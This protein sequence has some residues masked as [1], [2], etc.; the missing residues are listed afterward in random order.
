MNVWNFILAFDLLPE[1][2]S[3]YAGEVDSLF[4]FI[5]KAAIFFFVLIVALMIRFAIRYRRKEGGPEYGEGATGNVPLQI[6]WGL[7][8]FILVLVM[9]YRG[10]ESHVNLAIAPADVYEVEATAKRWEWSFRYQNGNEGNELHCWKGQPFRVVLRSEDVLHAFFVP[11][12]RIKVDVV[13]GRS[14]SAWFEATEAGS[15]ILRCAEYCGT[16]HWTHNA[17]VIV[18][19]TRM[20][21][22]QSL[23]RLGK[24]PDDVSN[25]DWGAH[26]WVKKGCKVCHSIDGSRGL[27]PSWL[28]T[29]ELYMHPQELRQ[30]EQGDPVQIDRAYLEES[31]ELPKVKVVK[32][33]AGGNMTFIKLSTEDLGYL[34]DFIVSLK[35]GE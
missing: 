14:S 2:R 7:I 30:F 18:H 23:E 6:T 32:G 8:P 11:E 34:I 12:F 26:L 16:D 22:E 1:A 4:Y 28:E 15:F 25:E 31:I 33:F 13:P 29:A 20:E 5:L 21:F 19:E 10:L 24:K 9:F 3:T 27:G 35:K 17:K